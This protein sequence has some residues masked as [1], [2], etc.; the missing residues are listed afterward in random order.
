MKCLYLLSLPAYSQNEIKL[1]WPKN[2]LGYLN[3]NFIWQICS[4][5]WIR[6]R[7]TSASV[8]SRIYL[9]W[10]IVFCGTKQNTMLRWS[11]ALFHK[12]LRLILRLIQWQN[13]IEIKLMIDLNFLW[14]GALS[15]I[16]FFNSTLAVL[17]QCKYH[18]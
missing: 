1:Y 5:V 13:L 18:I 9:I 3:P 11:R 15:Y 8:G 17:H 4:Q 14:N 16:F 6:L 2:N 10:L 12:D 7:L